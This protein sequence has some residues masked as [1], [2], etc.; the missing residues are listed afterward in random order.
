MLGMK[1]FPFPSP[2]SEQPTL[3][4]ELKN[5]KVFKPTCLFGFETD[6]GL[7]SVE[8]GKFHFARQEPITRPFSGKNSPK[9]R[10]SFHWGYNRF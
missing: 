5:D 1:R 3:L 9:G 7:V 6:W 4:F 8:R 2:E 10:E